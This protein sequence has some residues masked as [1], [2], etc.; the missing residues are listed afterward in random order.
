MGRI[1]EACDLDFW[2]ERLPPPREVLLERVVGCDGIVTLLTDRV[3]AELFDRAGPQLRVVSN[4]A[5][6]VDNVDLEAAAARGVIVGNTPD[7][8][9]ETTA[10]LTFA[11]ILAGMRRLLEGVEFIRRGEWVTWEPQGFLG[12]DV[13]GATLGIV[14][15]GRIGAAVARRARAFS[16]P[17]LFLGRRPMPAMAAA[18]DVE[19]VGSLAELLERSDVVSLHA[20]ATDA[21]RHMIDAAA[22]RQMKPTAVLVNTARGP[23]IDTTALIEGL[24]VGEIACAALDVTDPEPLPAD[25]PLVRHQRAIVVPHVGSATLTTRQKMAGIAAD[26]LL[27]VLRGE[28][29]RHVVALGG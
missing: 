14:G 12:H 6:G 13:Y 10:D 18:L 8:L 7:V 11:L 5:I 15:M 21:T 1:R 3:D 16:M 9:T 24:D 29:A 23:L 25:H 2:P 26:N 20:P 22:L 28:Q 27:R 17:T 19:Q 4:M